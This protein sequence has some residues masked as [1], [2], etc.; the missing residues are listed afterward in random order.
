M[1]TTVLILGLLNLLL[2]FLMAAYAE[3]ATA[4]L[5]A[6]CA[7][8]TAGGLPTLPQ[9][10]EVDVASPSPATPAHDQPFDIQSLP[11]DWQQLLQRKQVVPQ[12]TVEGLLWT[13]RFELATLRSQLI[14]WESQLIDIDQ[15]DPGEYA[16]LLGGWQKCHQKWDHLLSQFATR[17]ESD[18]DQTQPAIASSLRDLL[19]D[20]QFDAHQTAT[21]LTLLAD[22]NGTDSTDAAARSAGTLRR[23]LSEQID[24]LHLMRDRI[25]EILGTLLRT[26]GGLEAIDGTLQIENTSEVYNRI[27]FELIFQQWL[28]ANPNAAQ[29]VCCLL[30]DI[31][32]FAQKNERFGNEIGDVILA[33]FGGL[34]K[35]LIRGERGFDRVARFSGNSY[36][37]L[38]GGTL[39][40]EAAF[41]A[42]R[43]RQCIEATSFVVGG[44]SFD[45]TT[46]LG[47]VQYNPQVEVAGFYEALK[48][49]LTAAKN[50]GRNRTAVLRGQHA[51]IA[52]TAV[53]QVKGR[54]IEIAGRS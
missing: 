11:R 22:S 2:G 45:V 27:G 39:L 14:G 13:A 53:I 5:V 48:N 20:H 21:A 32:R 35:S 33:A 52:E 6:W 17:L 24:G 28:A 49:A 15:H 30:V 38:L 31:D 36:A 29:P 25:D 50:A 51:E 4:R 9:N 18:Q 12:S 44:D 1:I 34:L 42:E 3:Q 47:L 37:M 16:K 19:S 8:D 40:D 10:D 46:S 26:T 7:L 23:H 43:T 54:V 41:A